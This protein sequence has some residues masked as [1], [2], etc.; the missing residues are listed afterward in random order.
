MDE[1]CD[2]FYFLYISFY[3]VRQNIQVRPSQKPI[4]YQVLRSLLIYFTEMKL[5]FF[6]YF[7]ISG[8]AFLEIDGKLSP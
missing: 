2:N 6:C 7:I 8:L 3:L 5:L 1:M 4:M